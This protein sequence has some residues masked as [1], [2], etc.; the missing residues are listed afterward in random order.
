MSNPSG[1]G[2]PVSQPQTYHTGPQTAPNQWQQAAQWPAQQPTAASAVNGFAIA[3]LVCGVVGLVLFLI[4]PVALTLTVIGG[5]CA[6]IGLSVAGRTR[7]GQGMSVA[8]LVCSIVGAVLTVIVLAV[9][10]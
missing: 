4:P 8:G 3:G 7:A 5:I 2:Q 10:S 1:P 6:A 9:V